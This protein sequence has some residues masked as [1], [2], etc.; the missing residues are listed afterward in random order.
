MSWF[1][2]H[3]L[4]WLHL[5]VRSKRKYWCHYESLITHVLNP[6]CQA[7]FKILL[8]EIFTNNCDRSRFLSKHMCGCLETKHTIDRWRSLLSYPSQSHCGLTRGSAPLR[9]T[10]RGIFAPFCKRGRTLPGH[11]DVHGKT[12]QS[13]ANVATRTHLFFATL[14]FVLHFAKWRSVR[15]HPAFTWAIGLKVC[16]RL[17]DLHQIHGFFGN[18]ESCKNTQTLNF[19]KIRQCHGKLIL[20]FLE[21]PKITW[22][23]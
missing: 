7:H 17:G 9:L 12:K 19:Y 11:Y 2:Y 10:D 13:F 21:Q 18:T 23:I 4:Q 8:I 6:S 20:I 3:V 16:S 15:A 1:V 5:V 22:F 14:Q